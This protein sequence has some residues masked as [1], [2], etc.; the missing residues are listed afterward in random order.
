VLV[1]GI[2]LRAARAALGWSA[3]RL[4]DKTGVSRKTIERLE[5][6]RGPVSARPSTLAVILSLLEDHGLRL[7][8]QGNGRVGVTW[9]VHPAANGRSNGAANGHGLFA[10]RKTRE[11]RAPRLVE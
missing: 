6:S 8:D 10:P 9:C 7:V 11:W 3:Q 5:M 2:Q 1:T 4:A